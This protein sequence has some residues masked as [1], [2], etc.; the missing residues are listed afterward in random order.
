MVKFRL[1]GSHEFNQ[2]ADAPAAFIVITIGARNNRGER[3]SPFTEV[4]G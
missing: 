3:H 4:L 1:I 2:A